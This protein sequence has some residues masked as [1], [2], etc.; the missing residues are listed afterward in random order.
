M[1]S[2]DSCVAACTDDICWSNSEN[3][4][5]ATP[6]PTPTAAPSPI[7]EAPRALNASRFCASF[8]TSEPVFAVFCATASIPEM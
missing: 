8:S 1:F 7:A 2:V 4:A 5:I 3:F 6:R